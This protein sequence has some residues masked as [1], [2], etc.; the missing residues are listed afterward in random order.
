ML[1]IPSWWSKALAQRLEPCGKLRGRENLPPHH[2]GRP[3]EG[4]LGMR[5]G[6][7]RFHP[8]ALE[9]FG[10]HSEVKRAIKLALAESNQHAGKF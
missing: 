6:Y 5:G 8:I 1:K 2:S 10:F 3:E 7:F 4:L 9:R